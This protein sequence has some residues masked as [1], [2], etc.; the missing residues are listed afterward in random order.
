MKPERGKMQELLLKH[1]KE[2]KIDKS[3][4]VAAVSAVQ[5]DV[6]DIEDESSVSSSSSDSYHE[7]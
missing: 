5:D 6:N 4:L 3:F 7:V 1:E 2:S